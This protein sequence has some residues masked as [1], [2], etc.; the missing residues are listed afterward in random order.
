M[1]ATG[2]DLV[3]VERIGD[4][5]AR[6]G[7]RFLTRVFTATELT[8]CRGRPA[9]LAARFAAKE[10]ASKLLGIG[11]QHPEGVGWREIEVISDARGKPF[12]RLAGRA[13]QRAETL[14]LRNLAVSLSHSRDYAIAVVVAE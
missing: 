11:I 4:A 10:A 12:L 1:L 8:Y 13:A 9:E 6:Y 2:I 3:E 7:D 5:I 14:G